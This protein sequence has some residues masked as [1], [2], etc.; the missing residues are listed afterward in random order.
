MP[1]SLLFQS[2]FTPKNPQKLLPQSECSHHFFPSSTHGVVTRSCPATNPA[3][4]GPASFPRFLA[5]I[6]GV[7]FLQIGTRHPRRRGFICTT[8]LALATLM[9]PT[10][11]RGQSVPDAWNPNPETDIAGYTV[12]LGTSR[13]NLVPF[14]T[15]GK[16]T[17]S[18]VLRGLAP[19]TTYYCSVQ[20]FSNTGMKSGMSAQ[21]SF[22]TAAEPIYAGGIVLR[23]SNGAEMTSVT[24][25]IS[26]TPVTLGDSGLPETFTIHNPG[27]TALSGLVVTLDGVDP[28]AF[29]VSP[30]ATATLEPGEFT[31]FSITFRPNVAKNHSAV[32]RIS[33]SNA[34]NGS[35][36]E[37][38]LS[39]VGDTAAGLFN[40]WASAG[41]LSGANAAP[42][43]TPFGDGVRNLVKYGFNMDVSGP[44]ARTL[45]SGIGSTGLPVFTLDRT[46]SQFLF[47]VEFL[48]RKS[49][50]LTYTPKIS[51]DLR[52]FQVMTGTSSV[53]SIDETW[54]RVIVR[55]S[56]NPA[57]T[58]K[59]YGTVELS[60]P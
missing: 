2:A 57:V 30:L 59:V 32:L 22:T 25:E 51:E 12:Y 16:E 29:T 33:S 34:S 39:G 50:G 5:K 41:G 9:T 26:F 46:G 6:A 13:D 40:Q 15:V 54:E 47:S 31:A 44:D 8:L 43:T 37:L 7:R 28:S 49:S 36:F 27:S 18:S 56:C 60:L 48:R 4:A 45:I 11:L 21:L 10:T 1:L 24:D 52:N 20:A 14:Q 58:P 3:A 55:K 53:E 35:S 38:P 42:G 17:T 23:N 19:S